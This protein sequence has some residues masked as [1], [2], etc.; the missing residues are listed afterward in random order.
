[1]QALIQPV[2]TGFLGLLL[3]WVML[4]VMGPVYDTISNIRV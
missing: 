1:V 4:S 3:G 2:M